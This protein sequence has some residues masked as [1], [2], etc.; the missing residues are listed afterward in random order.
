[1]KFATSYFGNRILRH[2]SADMQQL[3]QQRFD[4]VVHTFSENDQ[5]YFAGTMKEI[6]GASRAN[7]LEVWLDPWGV[8]GVFGGEAFSRVAL[9][10]SSWAQTARDG[11]RLPACCPNNPNFRQFLASWIDAACEMKPDAIFWDEPH[12]YT[13]RIGRVP[14]CHCRHC[15][16]LARDRGIRDDDL[17]RGTST[18]LLLEWAFRR[19]RSRGGRNVVC[20]LPPELSEGGRVDWESIARIDGLDNLGTD[21]YWAILNTEPEPFIKRYAQKLNNVAAPATVPIHL[22]IQGFSIAA[23]HEEEITRAV[24]QAAEAK[25]E[26]IAIWGFEGCAAMSSLAC[27]NPHL[28]WEAFLK[29]AE[30]VRAQQD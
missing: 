8:G 29:G 17:L 13:D 27:E 25:P 6:V 12:F 26:V 11:S 14:G 24:I 23:G 28:A 16:I 19:V 5:R 1:M 4:L 9:E 30:T 3:A 15:E 18:L 22:W 21:P 7:G 2:V 20:L 10:E